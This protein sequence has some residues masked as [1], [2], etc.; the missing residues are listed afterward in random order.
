MINDFGVRLEGS[1]FSNKPD[2]IPKTI[3]GKNIR[4]ID[5]SETIVN[6]R[7]AGRKIPAGIELLL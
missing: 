4:D 5:F 1:A 7:T 2:K 6:S 3:A